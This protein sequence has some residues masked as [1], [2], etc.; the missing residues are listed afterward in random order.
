M[1]KL[2]HCTIVGST[3]TGICVKTNTKPM[4]EIGMPNKEIDPIPA[5]HRTVSGAITTTNIIMA[6]WSRQMWQIVVNRAIRMLTA[7]PLGSNF[8]SAVA[9][10]S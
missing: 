5:N 1:N 7:S 6:N 4:C 8:F 9:A 3:V 10:V 2:P